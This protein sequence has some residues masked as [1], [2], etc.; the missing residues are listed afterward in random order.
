MYKC[1]SLNKKAMYILFDFFRLYLSFNANHKSLF[2]I[3]AYIYMYIQK[4]KI[5]IR[6]NKQL[7][8]K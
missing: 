6:R 1:K 5:I 2:E 7:K 8:P 3:K 4:F